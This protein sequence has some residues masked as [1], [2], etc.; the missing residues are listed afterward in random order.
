M[1][2]VQGAPNC[3]LR[4]TPSPGDY[5]RQELTERGWLQVDLAEVTG[6][7]VGTISRILAGKCRITARTAIL[8][9]AAFGDDPSEWMERENLYRLE[10][11]KP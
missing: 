7:S 1:S 2:Q 10:D 5:L 11:L 8:F 3:E 9:G 4:H 6:C